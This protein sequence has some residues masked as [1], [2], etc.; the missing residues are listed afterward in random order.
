MSHSAV[1]TLADEFGEEHAGFELALTN[2]SGPFDVLLSLI[3]R[4]RMDVTEIALAEVTDEFLDYVATLETSEQVLENSTAFMVVAATLLEL[5]TARLLPA[6]IGDTHEELA[7]L[8]ERDLLFAR[9]LQY[10]AFKQ[11]A[12][13]IK[14]RVQTQ[15]AM[16]ARQGGPEP[17]HAN[18]LPELVFDLSPDDFATLA[19]DLFTKFV[20]EPDEVGTN[21]LHAPLVS[22]TEQVALM[23][24]RI[25][26]AQRT[27]FSTII[28]DATTTMIVVV[29][30]LGL[31]TMY[32]D[33]L[34]DWQQEQ[35]LGEITIEWRKSP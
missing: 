27:T 6:G 26:Q 20:E 31:L 23:T 9:L 14:S 33:R 24:Q 17:Q 21:H 19:K 34:I 5:K 18:L 3:A 2:F 15:T 29:R 28:S 12:E 11:A 16:I 7:L 8:E 25:Q 22:L 10:R 1:P 30:F 13:M 35:P 32:R 4:R